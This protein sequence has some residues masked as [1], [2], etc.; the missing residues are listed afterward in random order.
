MAGNAAIKAAPGSAAAHGKPPGHE[1][2]DGTDTDAVFVQQHVAPAVHAGLL[3]GKTQITH[4]EAVAQQIGIAITDVREIRHQIVPLQADF[5]GKVGIEIEIVAVGNHADAGP[6]GA[7]LVLLLVEAAQVVAQK[8]AQHQQIVHGHHDEGFVHDGLDLVLLQQ[9]LDALEHG[10]PAA[11]KGLVQRAAQRMQN[12]EPGLGGGVRHAHVHHGRGPV[13]GSHALAARTAFKG[14]A[15]QSAAPF[16]ALGMHPDFQTVPDQHFL[17]PQCAVQGK[18]GVALAA[19]LQAA[20]EKLNADG[21]FIEIA[22]DHQPG[23]GQKNVVGEEEPEGLLALLAHQHAAVVEQGL[24]HRRREIVVPADPEHMAHGA[25]VH[26]LA[27]GQAG[28]KLR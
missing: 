17:G 26:V 16:P 5:F 1:Q 28:Q 4:R 11:L 3:A 14:D 27:L 18:A 7:G 19:Q 15:G 22:P 9:R 13:H 25:H 20:G 21:Q 2:G 8:G 6:V 23:Q 12:G 24:V 10:A